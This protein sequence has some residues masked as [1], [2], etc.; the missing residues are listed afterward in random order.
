MVICFNLFWGIYELFLNWGGG[1]PEFLN[2]QNEMALK[3]T[4]KQSYISS[5]K[6]GRIAGTYNIIFELEDKLFVQ[7]IRSSLQ[8][9]LSICYLKTKPNGN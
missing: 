4:I 3:T 6:G 5:S 7:D 2:F 1:S 9:L 8:K